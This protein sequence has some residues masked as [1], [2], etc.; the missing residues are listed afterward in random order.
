MST[1]QFLAL[2]GSVLVFA[3]VL[4]GAYFTYR[5]KAGETVEA[6]EER[7]AKQQTDFVN[8]LFL[9]NKDKDAVIENQKQQI[10]KLTTIVNEVRQLKDETVRAN[11]ILTADLAACK[12]LASTLTA[13][14]QT[15]K[16]NVRTL[17]IDYAELARKQRRTQQPNRE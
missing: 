10:E 14:I 15:L 2:I 12:T 3:G 17:Q 7:M 16:E 4:T 1:E 6:R 11:E 8:A 5:G 9:A 13:E